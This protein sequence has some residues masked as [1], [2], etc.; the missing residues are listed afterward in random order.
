[1]GC[2]DAYAKNMCLAS[3]LLEKRVNVSILVDNLTDI[4][5][6]NLLKFFND[7]K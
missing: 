5:Q 2:S 6:I 7:Y 3:F 4:G 1:M